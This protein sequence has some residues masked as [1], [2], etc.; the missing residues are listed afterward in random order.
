MSCWIILMVLVLGLVRTV[1]GNMF[2]KQKA[3]KAG[4]ASL[5]GVCYKHYKTRKV[6]SKTNH[7]DFTEKWAESRGEEVLRWNYGVSLYRHRAHVYLPLM[8]LWPACTHGRRRCRLSQLAFHI[9][10]DVT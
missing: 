7:S 3:G 10:N 5:G 2:S 1:C 6:M 8:Q 4:F 9:V